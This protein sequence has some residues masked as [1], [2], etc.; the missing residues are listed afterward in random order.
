MTDAPNDDD[1][2]DPD[3][4]RFR[5]AVAEVAATYFSEAAVQTRKDV[6]LELERAGWDSAANWLRKRTKEI[7]ASLPGRRGRG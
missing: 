4:P 1:R 3:D 6:A 5:A 7:E 2:V